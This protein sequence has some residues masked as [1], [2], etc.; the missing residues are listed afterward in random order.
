MR[1]G[2]RAKSPA[3]PNPPPA[4]S[5]VARQPSPQQPDT[6]KLNGGNWFLTFCHEINYSITVNS[7]DYNIIY[8]VIIELDIDIDTCGFFR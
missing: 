6:D 4:T 3:A 7:V 8:I 2:P 5:P 1:Q